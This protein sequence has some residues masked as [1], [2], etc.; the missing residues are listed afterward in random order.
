MQSTLQLLQAYVE[1]ASASV[2]LILQV[3]ALLSVP[4]VLLRRRGKPMAKLS[5]LLALFAVPVLG[6]L[7]WWLI[8]RTHSYP[9]IPGTIGC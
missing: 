8:G 1:W 4:S 7:A 6:L 9:H 3:L 2:F 5:W